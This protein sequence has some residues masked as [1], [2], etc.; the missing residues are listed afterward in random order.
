MNIL[1]AINDP[2]LFGLWFRDRGTWK[3]WE[4]FLAALFALEMDE[5]QLALYRKHT[6]RQCFNAGLL[7]LPGPYRKIGF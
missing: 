7:N 1:Q 3:A 2:N 4:A 5:H 6:G